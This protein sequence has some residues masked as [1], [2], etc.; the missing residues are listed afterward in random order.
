MFWKAD[1]SSTVPHVIVR[2]GVTVFARQ[3]NRPVCLTSDID[4][5]HAC[6]VMTPRTL[7]L[8]LLCLAA[9]LIFSAESAFAE[10]WLNLVAR[11][12]ETKTLT[13][14]TGKMIEFLPSSGT[15]NT[16]L[17]T[18]L[19]YSGDNFATLS[20]NAVVNPPT[21]LIGPVILTLTAARFG[22][23]TAP[24][25]MVITYRLKVNQ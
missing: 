1:I 8:L 3:L 22:S 10:P 6:G 7:P 9:G 18:K 20:G 17:S 5:E 23:G 21:L 15:S 2:G 16:T 12:G 11:A 19:E 25:F 4:Q 13:V 24:S 14:P